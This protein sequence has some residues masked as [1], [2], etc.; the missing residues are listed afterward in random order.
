MVN[1]VDTHPH[2]VSTDTVRYPISP[3]GSERSEWSHERSVTTEE[4]IAAMDDAGVSQAALVHS[5]TTYGFACDYVADAVKTYPDRFTGVFSVNVLAPD[6]VEKMRDWFGKGLT[7]MRIYVKGT[8]VRT[9]WL[10]L[11]DPRLFPVY[12][13]AADCGITIAVNVNA[14]DGFEQLE[15]VLQRCPEV[16]FLLDHA[17]RAD[18]SQGVPFAAAAPLLSLSRF[19]NL[20][21]KLTSVNFLKGKGWEHP[22]PIIERLVSEFGASRIAWGSNYPASPGSLKALVAM[23]MRGCETLPAADR[24]RIFSKTAL[25]LYPALVA[26]AGVSP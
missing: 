18:Y 12:D 10:A 23:A 8:T 15:T 3:L 25:R 6:A 22:Q 21:L 2:V 14:T 9:A 17:G 11:D 4:L 7:G 19:P 24:E 20:F 16:D 13:C 26:H 1:I 5:S